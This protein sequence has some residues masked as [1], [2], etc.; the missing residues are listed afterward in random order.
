[1]SDQEDT[2]TR[3]RVHF[4]KS[5]LLRYTSHLDLA[6]IW[7]RLLRRAGL[8][9]VYSQGFNPRP[10]IQLAAA[11]PLGYTST[12]EVI[13]VWLFGEASADT[14]TV[15][16][17]LQA[18]APDGLDVQRAEMVDPR[19]PALQTVTRKAVYHITFSD[20]IDVAELRRAVE[21]VLIAETIM[22]E[23]RDKP[24]DLRPLIHDLKV[25]PAGEGDGPALVA[26]LNLSEAATGRPDELLEE[27]G[28]EPTRA[29]VERVAIQFAD[30][31]TE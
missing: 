8:N 17:R 7:E 2:R 9:V 12:S 27:L 3:L 30:T 6:R 14:S 20:T 19:G 16:D 1:V 24:Y 13:D 22:R 18:V 5:G 29:R 28:L 21:D 31:G 11:L 4:G 23:R 26:T 10:K 25:E 15:V